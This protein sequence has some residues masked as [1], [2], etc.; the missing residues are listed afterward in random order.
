MQRHF[1]E[2]NTEGYTAEQLDALNQE[3]AERCERLG[4]TPDALDYDE[5]F[6]RFSDEVSH[7]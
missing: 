6:K 2:Y 4:L 3:W 5:E 1:N 7:R